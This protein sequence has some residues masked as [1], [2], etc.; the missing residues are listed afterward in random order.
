MSLRQSNT[1]PLLWSILLHAGLL[2]GLALMALPCDRFES[3]FARAGLPAW[4]N[5]VECRQSL[6]VPGVVIEAT[7]VGAPA[8]APAR[9]VET[10]PP[11]PAAP[12]KAPE[13][14]PVRTLPPPPE[15]PAP[16][17][18]EKVVAIGE[19]QAQAKREQEA[20][21]RQR[22]A[23]LEADRLLAELDRVK[24]QSDAAERKRRLEEQRLQQLADLAASAQPAPE[25]PEAGETR[26]GGGGEEAGLMGEYAT[27]LTRTITGNWLRPENVPVAATCPIRITQIPGGQ[28]ISVDVLPGCPF[29]EAGRRSVKNAVLRAQPLPYAGFESVFQ[30]NI[31]LNFKVME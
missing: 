1:L 29:D 5:P 17:D 22:Q 10:A 24:A 20:L 3:F 16:K 4:L 2:S 26:T 8:A 23:E 15:K 13:P 11:R 27:A 21:E 30:R 18:Q 31:T 7:L 25:L 9:R 14:V 12:P 28:V 6:Q 19:V